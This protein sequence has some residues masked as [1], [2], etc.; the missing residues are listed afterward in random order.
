MNSQKL[1]NLLN[2]ALDATPEERAKSLN[3][4]V[5][6]DGR[7]K[8]WNLIVKYVGSLEGLRALGISAVELLSGYGILTVPEGL[9]EA[10]AEL[11]EIVFVEKPKRLNFAVLNGRSAACITPTQEGGMTLYGEGVIVAII[12]SGIDY[13]NPVFR[14]EDGSTRII[15][16]WDQTVEGN[17]PMS[18]NIGT[19]YSQED[20]DNDLPVSVDVSG[21]GTAVA[22]IA[23]GNFADNKNSNLG[24]ATKADI[25]V[26]KL[27]T[28]IEN[29]FPRTSELMQAIDF[30]IRKSV[31]LGKPIAINLSFG[32][33]YGSHDGTSLLETY[34]DEV[35]GVGVSTIVAGTGNEGAASGHTSGNVLMGQTVTIELV[36]NEFEPVMNV[37]I[38]K[39]YVDIF[40]IEIITPSGRRLNISG[41]TGGTFR[42]GT[43]LT[44]LLVYYGE[45]SPFSQYQEIY[46]DF[47]PRE[48]YITPGIW[49]INLYGEKIAYGK[50][51]LWLPSQANLN[52][53]RFVYPTPYTTL[54]IPSTAR[55]IISVGAYNS[56]NSSYA[57]F[58]GRGFDRTGGLI[59]PDI[60]APGVD[61]TTAVPGGGMITASG[62]SFATP[63]ATGGA[64]IL[65]EWGVVRGNDPYLYGEKVKAYMIRGAR[66]LQGEVSPSRTTGWGA[67]CVSDSFLR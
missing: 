55:Q 30:S 9:I 62:T 26:V 11:D 66:Q 53:S 17:P 21:H 35:S 20:I 67:L 7:D 48:T 14:N 41:R 13:R 1:E 18:Y 58:S 19:Y 51:D 60:V 5:G 2:L 6:Y 54:T 34:I 32:N 23:V 63:F 50:Y 38:W 49:T 27:G 31:E 57:D 52:G 28:P 8:M 42:Y 56:R 46:I 40:N 65:M 22:A 47:I 12:D 24:I 64:A 39:Y 43:D 3:L 33:T 45:P 59:K 37:Q 10:I 61:I 15:G 36:I 29:S 16:L 44:E 25:L 4:A